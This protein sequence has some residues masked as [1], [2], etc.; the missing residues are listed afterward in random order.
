MFRRR[1]D[2]CAAVPS[3]FGRM[4]H[5]RVEL[6]RRQPDMVSGEAQA[7]TPQSC[8]HARPAIVRGDGRQR[9]VPDPKLLQRRGTPRR[10]PHRNTGR[11]TRDFARREPHGRHP[12]PRQR[13]RPLHP[14]FDAID[15]AAAQ[16]TDGL[17]RE[18]TPAARVAGAVPG[19]LLGELPGWLRSQNWIMR[20]TGG[21]ITPTGRPFIDLLSYSPRERDH[22]RRWPLPT[23]SAVQLVKS[24]ASA[25]RPRGRNSAL[26]DQ[27]SVR[28]APEDPLAQWCDRQG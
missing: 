21:R 27:R 3:D 2:R 14:I 24:T 6:D 23:R 4:E 20:P 5:A 28:G 12:R 25:T 1:P 22:H 11:R 15:M 7:G 9:Q 13:Q 19:N 8:R 10:R 16:R 18:K 17:V 26:T